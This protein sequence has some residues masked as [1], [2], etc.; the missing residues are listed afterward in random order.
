[1]LISKLDM[2]YTFR[3]LT[4]KPGFVLLAILVLAGGLGLSLMSFTIS[5]SMT[6]KTLPVTNGEKIY[7]ICTRSKTNNCG[8]FDA[9]EFAQIRPQIKSMENIGIYTIR[10]NL[11]VT[12]E[13][14]PGNSHVIYTEPNLF[15]LT[16]SSALLGRTLEPFDIEPGA[17]AVVVV[18]YEYWQQHLGGTTDVIGKFMTVGGDISRIVGVMPQGY[19]MP[20]SDWLWAPIPRGFLQPEQGSLLPI[21]TFAFLRDEVKEEEADAE[22]NNLVAGLRAQYPFDPAQVA[23]ADPLRAYTSINVGGINRVNTGH[24]N[25]FPLSEFGSI[26]SVMIIFL[27]NIFTVLIF[28][29]A[30]INAG[31]LLLARTNERLRDISIRVALGAPRWR[32]FLQSLGE[33]IVIVVSGGLLALLLA[34]MGLEFISLIFNSLNGQILAFWMQ[35]QLDGSTL[36]G[37][38]LFMVLTILITGAVPVWRLINGNFNA[39]MRDG[40]RGA[41]GL[42]AGKTNRA[43]VV[44]SI[45]I[46]TVL[47]AL[48]TVAMSL[49]YPE[50]RSWRSLPANAVFAN[51]R[52][53]GEQYDA[54]RQRQFRRALSDQL[55]AEPDVAYVTIGAGLGAGRVQLETMT[56]EDADAGSS[57]QIVVS[58]YNP[59]LPQD[60]SFTPYNVPILL[61]G[62]YLTEFDQ[63]DTAAVALVSQMLAA[64]LWPGESALGKRIRIR[65]VRSVD[66][67]AWREVVGVHRARE[68]NSRLMSVQVENVTL[69]FSQVDTNGLPTSVTIFARSQEQT[70]A[71]KIAAARIV[72]GLDSGL[73]LQFT[74]LDELLD[75]LGR[76]VG[77]GT[78]LALCM[79]LFT[80]LVAIA[81]IYGLAQNGVQMATQ[82]IGTRR[83][84][85]ATD[86]S[87]SSTFLRRGTKQL[88][89]GFLIALLLGLPFLY[90]VSTIARSVGM[91]MGFPLL[92]M[93]LVLV[94][95]YCVILAAILMPIRRILRLEPAEALRYE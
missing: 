94:L 95:L 35:F 33:N 22:I 89:K 65:G 54:A 42:R 46:V 27:I 14:V 62:R 49:V 77:I 47:L 63:A 60:G 67:N 88:L 11:N 51:F 91:D 39:A 21:N 4:K 12:Y 40:T 84:L 29:L 19:R 43:L 31:T 71:V 76:S 16:G 66:E 10:N 79:A 5:Y 3:Q 92:M 36:I 57:A 2:K 81:G 50:T 83:A 93:A 90:I 18:G 37:A 75:G 69:P 28:L 9:F 25:V 55:M 8:P 17:E 34:G 6:Y 74:A 13:G 73:V 72:A 41:L 70:E 30:C 7:H 23:P 26:G 53:D 52:L 1:M 64:K 38:L 85:G 32:L 56:S 44:T 80:F 24:V 58:G 20:W 61:E 68:G 48:V 45:S 59:P 78:R 87:V 86:S 82:E 15:S